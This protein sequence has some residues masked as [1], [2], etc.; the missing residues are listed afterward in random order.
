MANGLDHYTC[1][2]LVEEL[3]QRPTW[4]GLVVASVDEAKPPLT[5]H[6]QRFE[7]RFNMETLELSHVR[8]LLEEVLTQ[9]PL[10]E[11]ASP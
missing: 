3:T 8:L 6:H 10:I 7:L 1:Q 11:D 2:E 9:L 4:V 5:T